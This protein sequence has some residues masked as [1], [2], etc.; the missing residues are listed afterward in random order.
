[1]R[2]ASSRR[3]VPMRV[4]IGGVFRRLEA[5]PHM[6]LGGEIV[7]LVGL[8]LLHDADQVG[9]IGHVAVMQDEAQVLLVRILVE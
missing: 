8:R 2:I 6:A 5:T 7:D 4:G 1:M 9:R 3:S